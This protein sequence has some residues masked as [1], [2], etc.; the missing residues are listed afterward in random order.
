MDAIWPIIDAD[1]AAW[2]GH[3]GDT[4]TRWDNG[5]YV[6]CSLLDTS[7]AFLVDSGST[8]TLV[9]KKLFKSISKEKRPQLIPMRDKVQGANG[10]DIEMLGI[11]DLPLELGGVCFFQTAIG[12][13]ILPDGI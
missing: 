4:A 10:G 8:A 13:G 12:C 9:S 5:F 1:L 11:A 7:A 3:L 6:D 2:I